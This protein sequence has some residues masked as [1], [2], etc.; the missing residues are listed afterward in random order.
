MDC[1]NIHLPKTEEKHCYAEFIRKPL[2]EIILKI[3]QV[4]QSSIFLKQRIV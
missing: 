4:Q 2:L 3:L 1:F